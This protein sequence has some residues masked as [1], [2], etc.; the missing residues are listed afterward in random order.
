MPEKVNNWF[1]FLRVNMFQIINK[2]KLFFQSKKIIWQILKL[3]SHIP[4]DLTASLRRPCYD[5]GRGTVAMDAA[6]TQRGRSE[7][8]KDAQGRR[9]SATILNM[10]KTVAEKQRA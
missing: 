4:H 6:G 10:H 8:P 5:Q 1:S 9:P 3:P 7:D 2:Y